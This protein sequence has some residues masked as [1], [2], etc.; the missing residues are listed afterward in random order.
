MLSNHSIPQFQNDNNNGISNLNSDN[1]IDASRHFVGSLN[2]RRIGKI[3]CIRLNKSNNGGFGIKIAERDN[4][5]GTKRPIYITAITTTGSAYRD[6]R[7]KE[8][9]M[10]LKIN[11]QDLSGLSQTSVTK[12]LKEVPT[13]ESVEFVVSRQESIDQNSDVRFEEK[14]DDILNMPIVDGP[15]IFIFD[16]PLKASAG[17]G[18]YL[19]YPRNQLKQDLGIWIDKVL[20]G[21]AA[22][23]DRRLQPND[24]ILAINGIELV[25]YSNSD[26]T[27]ILKAAVS[28]GIGPEASANTIRLKIHRR[29][30]KLVASILYPTSNNTGSSPSSSS[31]GE[32]EFVRDSFARKSISEKRHSQSMNKNTRN[33]KRIQKQSNQNSQIEPNQVDDIEYLYYN[34]QLHYPPR[35]IPRSNSFIAAIDNNKLTPSTTNINNS[36]LFR[37]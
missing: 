7:L 21:G 12:M 9:D 31:E 8:G 11:G 33:Y 6:G 5:F 19:K 36:S 1:S 34:L 20:H 25:T 2:T 15:G 16:I 14:V 3:H 27:K 17:L 26:A 10:I 28:R 4:M 18:L 29:N 30:P 24:Q 37:K 23:Q 35:P 22:W 13:S 32:G